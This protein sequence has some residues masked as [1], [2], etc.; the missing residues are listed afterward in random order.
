MQ[1]EVATPRDLS[2]ESAQQLCGEH[3]GLGPALQPELGQ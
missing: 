2:L 1:E 3:G